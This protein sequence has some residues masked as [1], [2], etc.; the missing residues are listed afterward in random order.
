MPNL[1]FVFRAARPLASAGET[2]ERDAL[3]IED[4]LSAVLENDVAGHV[5]ARSTRVTEVTRETTDD[6]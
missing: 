2:P 1:P 5:L 4:S 6:N 3:A